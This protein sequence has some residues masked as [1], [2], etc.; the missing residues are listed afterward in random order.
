LGKPCVV[1]CGTGSLEN[2]AGRLVTLD[3]GAGKVYDG[4]LAIEAPNEADHEAL[5][6]L[7]AWA[8]SR[9]PLRVTAPTAP[10]A[11]EAVDLS[12]NDAAADPTTIADVLKGLQGAR[13]ARGGAIASDEGVH[14][15][16]AA[17]LEFIV[18]DPILPPLLAAV[19]SRAS[20]TAAG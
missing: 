18:A 10:E 14:A 16:L 12:N 5:S 3:G 9:S 19:R 1:G 13:G 6:T 20:A 15:A 11:S 7:A 2:L 4:E 8:G 17:G